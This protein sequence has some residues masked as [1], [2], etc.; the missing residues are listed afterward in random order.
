[1]KAAF[2]AVVVLATPSTAWSALAENLTVSPRALSMGNA[3]T[4]DPP[5]VHSVHYNPA[6]LINLP[7]GGTNTLTLLAPTFKTGARFRAP[8][9]YEVFGFSDDPIIDTSHPEY[10]GNTSFTDKLTLY[11]PGG[12]I[13][14]PEAFTVPTA[15]LAY[16]PEDAPYVIA[17]TSYAPLAAGYQRG[18]DDPGRFQGKTLALQ[19]ITLLSPSIAVQVNENF[20]FGASIGMSYSAFFMDLDMRSPN[21]FV[22]V[23]R[24]L[25]ED[26]CPVF[27]GSGAI[28][29]IPP[30]CVGDGL[31]PFDTLTSI[32]LEA[33]D[34][35]GLSY[36]LG[37][38]WEPDPA[39]SIGMVYQSEAEMNFRG[40]FQTRN[41]EGL[42]T[43][44]DALQGD[45]FI[46]AIV[47]IL[48]LPTNV[49]EE[50]QGDFR[51]DLTLP[52][53]VAIGTK[54]QVTDRLQFNLDWRWTDWEKWAQ[55][56]MIL[57]RGTALTQLGSFLGVTTLTQLSIPQ[58]FVSRAH[59]A[60]GAKYHLNS[61]WELRAGWEPRKSSVPDDK[62]SLL[63][64]FSDANLYGVG[65]GYKMSNNQSFDF[66]LAYMESKV[67]APAN[68]STSLNATGIDNIVYNPYAGLDVD[69]ETEV[70]IAAI[71]ATMRF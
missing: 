63:V 41:S 31:N 6:G 19:R 1:M 30:D 48:G 27:E 60:F 9:G 70:F 35:F 67:S 23:V 16:R 68:S 2:V 29:F 43:T 54:L 3:V 11:V 39:L 8:E 21:E 34:P 33:T 37:F 18:E 56:D 15:G 52:E 38:L 25:K 64:P 26:V 69:I 65:V 71:T 20:A 62:V 4:A 14:E 40:E 28:P 12:D 46:A 55:L 45:P 13:V 59:F 32:T 17:S 66:S 5:G 58:G 22:G 42:V 61:R 53:H 57:N 51:L 36:N 10:Q 49:P 47:Q 50:E 24:F 7:N 44:F